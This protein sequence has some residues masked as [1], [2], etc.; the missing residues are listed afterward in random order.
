MEHAQLTE[1]EWAL[2]HWLDLNTIAWPAELAPNGGQGHSWELWT[3]PDGGLT[4]VDG[5]MTASSAVKQADLR[6]ASDGLT[7]EH[8]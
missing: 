5:E 2:G 7:V 8:L 6:E 3:A 4:L 1:P